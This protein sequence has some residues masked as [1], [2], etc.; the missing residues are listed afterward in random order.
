MCNACRSYKLLLEDAENIII[1]R[2]KKINLQSGSF[3][4]LSNSAKI[5]F[6]NELQNFDTTASKNLNE[7]I[8]NL[9]KFYT[10]Q[11]AQNLFDYN[12]TQNEIG[13][14]I[15]SCPS[16]FPYNTNNNVCSSK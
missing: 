6:L 7:I 5:A 10:D 4:L 9:N 13:F 11:A 2:A 8:T 14:C 3:S 16:E 1:S 15:S 12:D